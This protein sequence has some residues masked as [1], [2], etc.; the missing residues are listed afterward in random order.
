MWFQYF[1]LIMETN[2]HSVRLWPSHSD[3][4]STRHFFGQLGILITEVLFL[5][6]CGQPPPD[7]NCEPGYKPV[8][9]PNYGSNSGGYV[10]GCDLITVNPFT[11]YPDVKVP[12]DAVSGVDT[13]VIQK[14][15]NLKPGQRVVN[16][17]EP[18]GVPFGY[19]YGGQRISSGSQPQWVYIRDS[20]ATVK[21]MYDSL[22]AF[23]LVWPETRTTDDILKQATVRIS[24]D[25]T[26]LGSGTLLSGRVIGMDNLLFII[27]QDHV[28]RSAQGNFAGLKMIHPWYNITYTD[29]APIEW[30]I[31]P[32]TQFMGSFQNDLYVFVVETVNIPADYRERLKN[33]AVRQVLDHEWDTN[34]IVYAAGYAE[35]GSTPKLLVL[36]PVLE[37]ERSA[38][39]VPGPEGTPQ[40]T[41]APIFRHLR[42]KDGSLVYWGVDDT[43]D[44]T[45]PEDGFS[46]G[47]ILLGTKLVATTREIT[48]KGKYTLAW[49][50]DNLR[51]HLLKGVTALQPL[52]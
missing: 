34:G 22:D 33:M 48:L 12:E 50:L 18:D 26:M 49:P 28:M 21:E 42:H 7:W 44:D 4:R 6:S 46:G 30:P 20:P 52:P 47:P 17:Y 29:T 31:E 2:P 27:T 23:A 39:P 24:T 45:W 35:E 41:P 3:K 43:G 11:D 19:I 32:R 10:R 5:V 40:A 8:W 1:T 15:Y 9:S 25:A 16:L 14:D 13:T 36:N 38:R 51:L 37:E